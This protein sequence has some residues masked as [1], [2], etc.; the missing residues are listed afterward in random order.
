MD[1]IFSNIPAN[2]THRDLFLFAQEGARSWRPFARTPEI[3]YCEI[4]DIWDEDSGTVEYHG[5]VRF[6]DPEVAE[7]ALRRLNGRRFNGK[8]IFVREYLRRSPGDRRVT[9]DRL[10]RERPPERRR[11]NLKI[12]ARGERKVE[13]RKDNIPDDS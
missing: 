7:R 6:P 12:T 11:P 13:V 2:T 9:E 8:K 4:L 1:L 10:G 3:T 5:L